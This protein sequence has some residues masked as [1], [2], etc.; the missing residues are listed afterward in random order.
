MRAIDET[1]K[2]CGLAKSARRREEPDRL[3][4]PGFVKRMLADRHKLDVGVS[5]VRRVGDQLIPQLV[6]AEKRSI[7][8][9]PPRAEV[10]LVDGHGLPAQFT[11]AAPGHIFGV[12]PGEVGAVG[13]HRRGRRPQLGFEAER[14]GLQRQQRAVGSRKLEFVDGSG[15]EV[16]DEDLPQPAVH[17][18][19]HLAAASV[20]SI[21]IADDG[22][23]RGVRRPE[24]EQHALDAF[25]LGK[26]RPE[27]AVQ[28]AMGAFAQEIVVERTESRSK[29]IRVQC[30]VRSGRRLDLDPIDGTLLEGRDQRF[31]EVVLAARQ[32]R[33]ELSVEGYRPHADGVRRKDA[34]N[35]AVGGLV[36]SKHGERIARARRLNC[37]DVGVTRPPSLHVF[38]SRSSVQVS[39]L[40]GAFQIS[41]AYSAMVR[42]DENHPTLAV[43][44]MLDR[45]QFFR[46]RQA[47]STRICVAK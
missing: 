30:R 14:I 19:A 6:V 18:L 23:A 25:V 39:G 45:I 9:P 32:F 41:D 16:R 20:P 40:N 46:S 12:C 37:G 7:G 8:A 4:A 42:S 24:G 5:H 3:V 31:E 17:A 38:S 35:P 27:A 29:R 36:R 10:D 43:L 15:L 47:S 28:L 1:G 2:P 33:E 34:N 21:E 44:R 11:V 26:L 22:G 13:D